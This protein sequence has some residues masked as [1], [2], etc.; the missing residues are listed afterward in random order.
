MRGLK[1]ERKKSII[2]NN[3]SNILVDGTRRVLRNEGADPREE[4]KKQLGTREKKA[5]TK[6]GRPQTVVVD[7]AGPAQLYKVGS[8]FLLLFLWRFVRAILFF[9]FLCRYSAIGQKIS[10]TFSFSTSP[11]ISTS[12]Q[13]SSFLWFSSSSL[14]TWRTLSRK[15]LV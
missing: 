4:A 3:S 9:F 15:T 10:L 6:T 7:V 13:K 12:S 8:Y 14:S 2:R 1:L 11:L 5:R